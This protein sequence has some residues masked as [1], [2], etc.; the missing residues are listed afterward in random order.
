[1]KGLIP[2]YQTG[3][4][5]DVAKM[6]SDFLKN[7]DYVK[8]NKDGTSY[9]TRKG[10]KVFAAMEELKRS[11][12]NGDTYEYD[13][14]SE[15]YKVFNKETNAVNVNS[16]LKTDESKLNLNL[17]KENRQS[18]RL[19]KEIS[20][21][22]PKYATSKE[23]I[24]GVVNKKIEALPVDYK[25]I[26]LNPKK[27]EEKEEGDQNLNSS[28]V[29]VGSKLQSLASFKP[30]NFTQKPDP[31]LLLLS[32]N[33]LQSSD[34]FKPYKPSSPLDKYTLISKD[35]SWLKT[36]YQ[37]PL[38]KSQKKG[39]ALVTKH[40]SYSNLGGGNNF[41]LK[42]PG[43]TNP[44]ATGNS[45]TNSTLTG[46]STLTNNNTSS[47]AM[48]L[49]QSGMI[50]TKPKGLTSVTLDNPFTKKFNLNNF[51]LGTNSFGNKYDDNYFKAMK[52]QAQ[53]DYNR[54]QEKVDA[55]T[56]PGFITRQGIVNRG[57]NFNLAG[58]GQKL[59]PHAGL[60]FNTL[61]NVGQLAMALKAA[62]EPI[63]RIDPMVVKNAK[64]QALPNVLAEQALV[65]TGE[66][67][68]ISKIAPVATSDVNQQII[69][70]N[71]ANAQ[72]QA[73]LG[74]IAVKSGL[75]RSSE[76]A[77]VNSE[78][79]TWAAANRYNDNTDIETGNINEAARKDAEFK[80]ALAEKERKER[81]YAA[82]GGFLGN[83]LQ[84]V[85]AH[86]DNLRNA[87]FTAGLYDMQQKGED[88]KA[89]KSA[90]LYAR[91]QQPTADF[92]KEE[93]ELAQSKTAYDEMSTAFRKKYFGYLGSDKT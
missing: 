21:L 76:R 80:N 67:N 18:H 91:S 87:K 54:S 47:G 57:I 73:M 90:L 29:E 79:N 48:F 50:F 60:I 59:A 65:T 83:T 63:A 55:P 62:K 78:M 56:D 42:N 84:G 15:N 52:L 16:G 19:N 66:L 17:K 68:K 5:L 37:S 25:T 20:K 35:H 32:N 43:L 4:P 69:S 74:D 12:A 26:D 11:N 71:L 40:Q 33:K 30:F 1:M 31:K 82:W 7:T 45:L 22:I 8:A 58:V 36:P 2:K 14:L 70:G 41:G 10:K 13:P 77:R 93:K 49:P 23:A 85:G 81:K 9:M 86:A 24:E 3:K 39:G 28:D 46:G 27:E 64:K 92:S 88:Y 38:V 6:Q 72:K 51:T 89:N 34:I 75:N 61:G 44:F 53:N